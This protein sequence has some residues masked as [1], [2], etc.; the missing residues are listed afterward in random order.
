MTHA[1]L[2]LPL[3]DY[4]DAVKFLGSRG[5]TEEEI[6]DVLEVGRSELR[7]HF[8]AHPILRLTHRRHVALERV[9]ARSAVIEMS[10][11]VE[12]VGLKHSQRVPLARDRSQVAGIDKPEVEKGT[13]ATDASWRELVASAR[14]HSR[15]RDTRFAYRPWLAGM[16]FWEKV[17]RLAG[18]RVDGIGAL[19]RLIYDGKL[20]G[21]SLGISKS[22]VRRGLLRIEGVG[23]F[24]R[25]GR[26]V[27]AMPSMTGGDGAT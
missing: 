8:E 6:A 22:E 18:E 9:L 15:D 24:A 21:K 4:V 16:R 10:D 25:A 3:E 2:P 27:P 20:D 1:G 12:G 5:A 19:Y 7:Q 23:A 13:E 26:K 11:F 14:T 17:E